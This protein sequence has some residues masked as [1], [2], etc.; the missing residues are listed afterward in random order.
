MYGNNIINLYG[1]DVEI[2]NML[3]ESIK[4]IQKEYPYVKRIGILCTNGTRNTNLYRNLLVSN[5]FEPI[6]V[7][8]DIQSKVHNVIYNPIWG[9][10]ATSSPVSSEA[11]DILEEV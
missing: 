8:D 9:I 4:D 10:K 6:Y 1:T 11:K 5:N 7:S 2:I 3:H